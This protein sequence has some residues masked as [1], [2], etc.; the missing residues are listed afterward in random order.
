MEP[1]RQFFQFL[2]KFVPLQEAEFDLVIR[3]FLQLRSFSKKEI[4]THAGQTEQYLNF[5]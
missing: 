5:V 4:I 1:F 3:P 2:N